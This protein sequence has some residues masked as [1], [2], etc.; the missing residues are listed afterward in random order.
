M[1][2]ARPDVS[3]VICTRNRAGQLQGTLDS[4]LAMK[5]ARS[6]DAILIDNAS[7]DGTADVIRRCSETEPR[8]RYFREYRVGLGAAGDRGWR[9][10]QAAVVARSDV[11]W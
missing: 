10:A 6:W 1:T 2:F 11:V 3:I 9:V 4:L 5:T 8:I 7:T